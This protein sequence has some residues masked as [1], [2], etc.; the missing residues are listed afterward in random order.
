NGNNG[1]ANGNKDPTNGNKG[2]TN[3]NKDPGNEQLNQLNCA[4]LNCTQLNR[5]QPHRVCPR[6]LPL[7][8]TKR[9]SADNKSMTPG[10]NITINAPTS[11][12][13]DGMKRHKTGTPNEDTEISAIIIG[14]VFVGAMVVYTRVDPTTTAPTVSY[15][16]H[17]YGYSHQDIYADEPQLV[18]S[19]CKAKVLKRFLE[20]HAWMHLS[21]VTHVGDRYPFRCTHCEFSAFR[22][23]D[24]IYHAVEIHDNV[25]PTLFIPNVTDDILDHFLQKVKECF[26]PSD[27]GDA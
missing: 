15:R 23:P 4:Q 22:I 14:N 17:F 13:Y 25:G 2:R 9:A 16:R 21:W 1:P 11:N 12:G 24:V 26:P 5:L 18:C 7:N 20:L 19:V 8:A 6:Q 10:A 27:S 3:G